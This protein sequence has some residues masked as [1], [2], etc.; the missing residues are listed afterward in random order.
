MFLM[1]QLRNASDDAWE[2]VFLYIMMYKNTPSQASSE[3]FL[4]WYIKNM[5]AY[6]EQNLLSGLPVLKSITAL[7]AFTKQT[8]KVAAINDW[9]PVA[10]TYAAQGSELSPALAQ[11]DGG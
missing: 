5:K 4:S 10:K 8:N 1:Y 7:P 3:A 6:W 2:G 9:T 11:V